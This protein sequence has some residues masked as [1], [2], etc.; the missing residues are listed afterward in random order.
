MP[1]GMHAHHFNFFLKH[2][3]F[4]SSLFA[5]VQF[6][7]SLSPTHPSMMPTGIP[8]IRGVA[9]AGGARVPLRGGPM[10]RGDYGES[11]INFYEQ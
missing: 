10:G 3:I 5:R 6:Y 7:R 8:P 2:K 9:G 1:L 4:I 11:F